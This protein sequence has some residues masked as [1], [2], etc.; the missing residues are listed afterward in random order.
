MMILFNLVTI[1]LIPL[2]ILYS[3]KKTILPF[4]YLILI[5]IIPYILDNDVNTF[6]FDIIY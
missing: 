6:F 1:N 5:H 3:F 4:I 2:I